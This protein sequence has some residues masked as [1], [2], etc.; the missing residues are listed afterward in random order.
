MEG[1]YAGVESRPGW[2]RTHGVQEA[3]ALFASWV[4]IMDLMTNADF[5]QQRIYI[6]CRGDALTLVFKR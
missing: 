1:T 4:W 5:N 6:V 2:W 3:Q